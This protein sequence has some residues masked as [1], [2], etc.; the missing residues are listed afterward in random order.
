MRDAAQAVPGPTIIGIAIPSVVTLP[1]DPHSTLGPHITLLSAGWVAAPTTLYIVR[2]L[3]RLAP[4]LRPT[5]VVLGGLGHFHPQDRSVAYV[6]VLTPEIL[7]W[8]ALIEIELAHSGIFGT[9]KAPNFVPHATVAVLPP[10]TTWTGPVPSG[11]F[12]ADALTI[13]CGLQ[14]WTVEIGPSR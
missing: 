6:N 14:T 7:D 13:W 8:R 3:R 10:K 5:E 4:T 11:S 9:S 12:V 1:P 2:I